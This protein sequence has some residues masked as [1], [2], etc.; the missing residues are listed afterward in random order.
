MSANSGS[1]DSIDEGHH[2]TPK[3]R[4]SLRPS[5]ASRQ[6]HSYR[7]VEQYSDNDSRDHY[8]PT[9]KPVRSK[10][11]SNARPRPRRYNNKQT[12]YVDSE[13]SNGYSSDDSHHSKRS[14]RKKRKYYQQRSRSYSVSDDDDSNLPPERSS[15]RRIKLERPSNKTVISRKIASD[16]DDRK[17]PPQR[18]ARRRKEQERSLIQTKKIVKLMKSI[19]IRLQ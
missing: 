16:D 13:E 1:D 7:H 2:T 9:N 11:K 5:S 4:R 15:R 6:G 19:P 8:S 18:I 17:L 10:K 12:V 14:R 3:R